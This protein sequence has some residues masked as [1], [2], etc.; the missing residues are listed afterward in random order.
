[1]RHTPRPLSRRSHAARLGPSS[2]ATLT[3]LSSLVL[4]RPGTAE[5]QPPPAAPEAIDFNRDIRPIL[6]ENCYQCH[7]P[8]KNQR[9]ADLRLDVRE[10]ALE[11]E[12]IVPGK[13]DESELVARILSDDADELMP[14]SKSRKSLTPAQKQ[15][16]ER[17]VAEGAIYKGHWA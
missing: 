2:L 16:L 1:M 10:S 15:T 5:E 14:P 3:L 9:K 12:A 8:D 4:G 17:W 13:P 7:G 11:H 6:S